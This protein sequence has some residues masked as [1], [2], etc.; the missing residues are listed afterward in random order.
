MPHSF[1]IFCFILVGLGLSIACHAANYNAPAEYTL[2]EWH[3]ADGLPSDEIGGLMQ[4]ESG[5]F[6]GTSFDQVK[7]PPDVAA[8]GMTYCHAGPL[9]GVTGIVAPG[10]IETNADGN[11]PGNTDGFYVRTNGVFHFVQE[12][13]LSGKTVK[14]L[15][16]EQNGTLWLGCE[17]GTILRRHGQES[18]IFSPP[19]GLIGKKTPVFATDGAKQLWVSIN[20]F[21][22]HFDGAN[23]IP[24]PVEHGEAE[25]RIA[26]SRNDGPWL[27]TR[28]TLFKW[29][30]N[31]LKE[32]TKL[33][34]LLGTHF[35]QATVEDQHGALWIGTRSQGLFRINGK[36]VLHVPTSHDDVY[37]LLEDTEGG[38]WIGTNGGGL[39]RLR[40]KAH[41][42]YDKTSGLKDNFSYTVSEDANGVIWLANRDGGVARIINGEVDPISRRAG[43]RPF[44]AMSIYPSPDGVWVTTGIGVYRTDINEPDKLLRVRSLDSFKIV[45]TTLVARNGDY[46]LT[47]DPDRVARWRDDKVTIFGP[48][49]GLDGRE[50]RAIAE[51]AS[52]AI[53]V[54]AADG[55]LFRNRGEQFERVPFEGSEN[56][57]SLQVLRFEE[58]GTLLIG[59]TRKGVL[60]FPRGNLTHPRVLSSEQGMLNNNVSQILADD[61]D[62]YWFGSRGGIFRIHRSQLREFIENRTDRIHPIMLGKDDG[63]PDLSCLGLFQPSAWKGIDGNIWFATRQGM[64]R[65]NPAL[66]S[67]D[68]NPVPVTISAVKYDGRAQTVNDEMELRSTVRKTEIHFSALKLSTPE[69]VLV[70]YRLDGFDND[71]VLQTIG[72]VATYPRLPPGSYVF[73]VMA[74]NGND[75]WDHPGAMLKISVYPPWWQRLWAELLYLLALV[76]VVAAFVRGWSHRRLRMRLERLEREQAVERERT[77]IAQNIHDDLGASL[78]RISLL[79]QSAQQGKSDQAAKFEEIYETA[80]AITRS[81]DE[82]VWAVNPKCD[83]MEN[84]VYYVGNFA[85]GFLGSAGIRCRLDLPKTLSTIRLTSQVR[86]N[87]FLC[88]KEALNNVVK[89]AQAT[90]VIVTFTVS[91][92]TL[93]ITVVD[94]GRGIAA[95]KKAASSSPHLGNASDGNGLNNMRRRMAEMGGNCAISTEAEAGTTVTFT[96]A[97]PPRPA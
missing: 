58:E 73:R 52:G 49:E 40:P 67:G 85:Q 4:D 77:R 62:R 72:R 79:T 42:L 92:S 96:I 16:T 36:D 81:M 48:A 80:H 2:R 22:A 83:D 94:N 31:E 28:T 61:S 88:C 1:R 68:E 24:L 32:I 27:F 45:R 19:D 93:Q 34:E 35:I 10:N 47:L 3:V 7:T 74:S 12:P 91:D 63:V 78:T 50:V 71:W 64:L 37:S 89:H 26:S 54:G 17:D 30:G 23:W 18:E 86:H 41:R 82:I 56:S 84:L 43:W 59:T 15:F 14:V 55:K 69:R 95:A 25:V 46:W 6:H 21:V 38:I 76:L 90:E 9:S 70:R 33:P 29:T 60:V 87:L 66:T 65:I 75:E 20:T 11:S 51:D 97:L 57:G 44:S 53:W 5:Y 13:K 39:N 8:R